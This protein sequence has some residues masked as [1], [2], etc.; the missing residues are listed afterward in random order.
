MNRNGKLRKLNT[1]GKSMI[2]AATYGNLHLSGNYGI[3]STNKVIPEFHTLKKEKLE[4]YDT[5]S[6][7]LILDFDRNRIVTSPLVSGDAVLETFPAFSADGNSIFYCAAPSV[8][9]PDSIRQLKYSLCRIDF[10]A[11][12]GC[13]GERTDTILSV[14]KF[15]SSVSFPRPSPDGRFLLYSVSDYGTFPIWHRETDLQLL[16]L[17][18]G[19]VDSLKTVNGDCSD[20]YHSWSSNSRWFVFASKRDDGLYGKPYFCY[21]DSEGKA[22]KPFVL[23]QRN[24]YYYDFTLKSF[25]IP[26]LSIGKLPFDAADIEKLYTEGLTEQYEAQYDK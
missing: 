14:E 10:D 23:P 8:P 26:E 9:L 18:T 6:D 13:F 20:T 4:V 25:N 22:H 2:G 16:N 5:A 19:T 3:F 17:Q 11:K 15:G 21:V 1:K 12:K 24:P 7:L